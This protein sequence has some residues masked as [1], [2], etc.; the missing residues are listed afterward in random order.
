VGASR[1]PGRTP[2]QPGLELLAEV[3]DQLPDVVFF[4]KDEG[5]RYVAA[6]RTLFER[7]GIRHNKGLLGRTAEQV[8]PPPFGQSFGAQDRLVLR[9]GVTIR[10]KLERHLYPGGGEGWCLTF[11]T[12]LRGPGGSISGLVGISRDLHRP[13]ERHPEYR[14]LA[15]AVESL[16]RRC[17]EPVRLAALAAQSGL[18]MDRLER[19][20][21]RVFHLTPRQLLGQMRL[22]AAS[23]RLQQGGS[24]IAEVAQA[25]GYSDHSAFT[26][27]FKATVGLTPR[28]FR[29]AAMGAPQSPRGTQGLA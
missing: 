23:K 13:D 4:V 28:A 5:G 16:Q 10:D 15:A 7:C 11:K 19:L 17:S 24:T 2:P 8:F 25:C 6:N 20:V 18:S 29:K 1:R 27:H 22:E 9:D 14:L 26:R 21:K 3:F 12:P